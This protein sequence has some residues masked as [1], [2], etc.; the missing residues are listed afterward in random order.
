MPS[1][2]HVGLVVPG[3]S[4]PSGLAIR[5]SKA[6]AS[7]VAIHLRERPTRPSAT[8]ALRLD[9]LFDSAFAEFRE[10]ERN[11]SRFL[12]ASAL[13]RANRRPNS[14]HLVPQSLME[15][16]QCALDAHEQTSASFDPR[17]LDRLVELGYDRSFHLLADEN[18]ISRRTADSPATPAGVPPI[19]SPQPWSPTLLPRLRLAHLGGCRVDLG[20]IGKSVAARRAAAVLRRSTRDFLIDAGGD[21]VVSGRPAPGALWRVGV[22]APS[23]VAEPLVV[24]EVSDTAVATSSVRV[25]HWVHEGRSVHHLIDPRTGEPGGAGLQAVSVVHPDPV[26]AEV[27]AK[28]LFLEGADRI[29]ERAAAERIAALWVDVEERVQMTDSMDDKVIWARD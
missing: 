19:G 26:R 13:S 14:W 9:E 22:E 29:R 15:T 25:R 23:G 21:L 17:V 27:W 7:I 28:A 1:L 10:V 20:G 2:E 8:K 12:P 11:C 18:H 5:T 16:M 6:M 4:A 24:L 3:K